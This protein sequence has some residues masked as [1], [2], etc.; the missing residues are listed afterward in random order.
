[1]IHFYPSSPRFSLFPPAT[2]LFLLASIFPARDFLS[3]IDMDENR[4]FV[5]NKQKGHI[6]Q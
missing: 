5:Y 4:S 6:E 2:F 1:M 3:G